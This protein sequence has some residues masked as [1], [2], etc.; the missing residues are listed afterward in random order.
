[1]DEKL[2]K[3]Y[4]QVVKTVVEQGEQIKKLNGIVMALQVDVNKLKHE[5]LTQSM[6][7]E[8]KSQFERVFVPDDEK[9]SEINSDSPKTEDTKPVETHDQK[10]LGC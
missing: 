8:D 2:K 1:M 4:L 10:T 7:P 9:T 3:H 5:V 6:S